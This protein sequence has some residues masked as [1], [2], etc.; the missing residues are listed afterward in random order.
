[1]IPGVE[2]FV[3]LVQGSPFAVP[4]TT[5]AAP[6]GRDAIPACVNGAFSD[7][8]AIAIAHGLIS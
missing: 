5:D 8:G 6:G 3:E 1:M 4:Q 7:V 2:E